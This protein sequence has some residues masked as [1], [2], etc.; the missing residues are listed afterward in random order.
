[1]CLIPF[2]VTIPPEERIDQEVLLDELWR[3]A[4]GILAWIVRGNVDYRKQGLAIPPDLQAAS[5]DYRREQDALKGFLA[6][7]CV[8][9]PSA[10]VKVGALYEEYKRWADASG[11]PK[12]SKRRLNERLTERG[13]ESTDSIYRQGSTGRWWNG[14][15]LRAADDVLF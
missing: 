6:D 9:A 3:E 15:G 4:P 1:P 12:L 5:D 8:V 7:C 14:V 10:T 2:E 11:E 13:F